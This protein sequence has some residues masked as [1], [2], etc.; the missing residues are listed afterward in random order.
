[1]SS[2]DIVE[3]TVLVLDHSRSMARRDI[4][5]S[6]FLASKLA[7][8]KFARKKL[9]LNAQNQIGIVAFGE[10]ARKLLFF[11]NEGSKIEDAIASIS[12][13]GKVSYIGAAIALGIQMHVDM[14]RQISGKIS[15]MIV[16][17]DGRYTRN[18]AMDPLQMAKLAHGLGIQIDTIGVGSDEPAQILRQV[19][20]LTGG[21][22]I[23]SASQEDLDFVTDA[24]VKPLSEET[25]DYL[26]SKKP[27]LSD[28]AGELVSMEEMNPS[29]RTRIEGMSQ[30]EREKCLIC[31]KS[32]CPV[33]GQSYLED[34]RY[35]PN[36]GALMHLHCASGWA[37]S[38]KKTG[39]DTNVFRCPKCYYLLKVP[40]QVQEEEPI[41]ST[42]S[43]ARAPATP[44]VTAAPANESMQARAPPIVGT[45]LVNKVTPLEIGVDAMLGATCAA[46]GKEIEDEDYLFECPD[47]D[48]SALYHPKCFEKMKDARGL[49]PCKRCGTLL[50]L[51][52]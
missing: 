5:P 1:M 48:C 22:Y 17:S 18:T 52:D 36:C 33:C 50:R 45:Q 51:V 16:I 23:V 8:T 29:Q 11:T 41:K 42:L 30:A 12:M 47:L 19:A 7:M 9:T 4:D 2:A 46:C 44:R 32:D 24:L 27:L 14:L 26:K 39:M 38:N 3:D 10:K 6:R 15:R 21:K 43:A 13:E 25:R 34:G 20:E 40:V 28:L 31:F 35:C 37:A 49:Y